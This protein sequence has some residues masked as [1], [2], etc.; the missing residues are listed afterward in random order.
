MRTFLAALV[1]SLLAT[2]A[3]AALVLY[4]G[5]DYPAGAQINGQTNTAYGVSWSKPSAPA[6]NSATALIDA[7]DVHYPGLPNEAD[8]SLGLSRTTQSNISRIAIPGSPYNHNSASTSVFFSFVMQMTSVVSTSDTIAASA[9]HRDGD[10]IAGFT[11]SA[12]SNPITMAGANSYAGQVRIRREL[13]GNGVQTGEYELGFHKNNSGGAGNWAPTWDTTQEF[14]EDE[15]VFVVGEYQFNADGVEGI[16]NDVVRMWI[17]PTPGAAAPTPSVV[18]SFGNDVYTT[19]AGPVNV[20]G[21]INS[22][23]FRDGSTFLPGPTLVDELRVGTTFASVTPIPEPSTFALA[24]LGLALAGLTR[25][26]R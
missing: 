10:F 9:T 2:P 19:I 16:Q 22:F 8:R 23:W 13:D 12:D 6:G 7:A 21:N 24:G 4:D 20:Q 11:S 18:S 25:R 14:A 15:T 17:N 26:K 3:S 1:L 5:F